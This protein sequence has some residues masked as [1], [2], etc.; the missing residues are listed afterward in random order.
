MSLMQKF[1]LVFVVVLLPHWNHT[2]PHFMG[3]WKTD[4]P[5]SGTTV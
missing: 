5:K 4:P 3:K 1:W 2:C